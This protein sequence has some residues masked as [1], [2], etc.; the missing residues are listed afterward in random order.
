MGFSL[1]NAAR[2]ALQIRIEQSEVID[3]VFVFVRVA[4]EF[5]S[6]GELRGLLKSPQLDESAVR[7]KFLNLNSNL[8]EL[9]WRW[10]PTIYPRHQFLATDLYETDGMKF[11]LPSPICQ[12][13]MHATLDVEKGSFVFQ[14]LEPF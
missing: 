7:N 14:G 13:L 12:R 1:T 9:N 5:Q 8:D 10:A 3:P 4:M 2:K 11:L 6:D